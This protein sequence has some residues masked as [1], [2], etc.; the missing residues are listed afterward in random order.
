MTQTARPGLLL[1]TYFVSHLHFNL[2]LMNVKPR[3]QINN[4]KNIRPLKS[5]GTMQIHQ[6]TRL[7]HC[8]PG[9]THLLAGGEWHYREWHIQSDTNLFLSPA[10]QYIFIES[11]GYLSRDNLVS[12]K[13]LNGFCGDSGV[14]FNLFLIYYSR[15]EKEKNWM[16]DG[17]KLVLSLPTIPKRPVG[18][19]HRDWARLPHPSP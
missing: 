5:G 4:R 15:Y 7:Y 14:K 19:Y 18:L 17:L 13:N 11:G 6:S 10:L 3:L 1:T 9:G 8:V 16:S 2:G 12:M